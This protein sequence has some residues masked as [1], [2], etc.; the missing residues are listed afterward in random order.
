MERG[1]RWDIFHHMAL[2]CFPPVSATIL[3]PWVSGRVELSER[4]GESTESG[5]GIWVSSHGLL[6]SWPVSEPKT[7]GQEVLPEHL[8]DLEE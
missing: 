1:D 6:K 3:S 2:M 8:E 7:Q 5:T 4:E